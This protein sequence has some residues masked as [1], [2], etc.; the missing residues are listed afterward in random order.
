[1][2]GSTSAG[3]QQLENDA[4][5]EVECC[6]VLQIGCSEGEAERKCKLMK[7]LDMSGLLDTEQKECFRTFLAEHHEAFC[8]DPGEHG[9]TDLVQLEVN[10]GDATP[11]RLLVR[12]MPFT[13][14]QVRYI[15][16][17]TELRIGLG[18]HKIP[19]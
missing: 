18:S 2:Y 5:L 8:I 3:K 7:M 11:L 19:C 17:Y 1:M 16:M 4:S 12:R 14:K 9:E 10:T 15:W 6:E 13:V